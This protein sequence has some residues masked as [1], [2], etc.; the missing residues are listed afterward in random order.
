MK[1]IPIAFRIV[2]NILLFVIYSF[3]WVIFGNFL[4][5]LIMTI[6]WKVVAWPY[7][8]IHTKIAILSILVIFLISGLFRKYFYLPIF[9]KQEVDKNPKIKKVNNK[10]E[11]KNKQKDE[12]MKIYLDKEIK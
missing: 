2:L 7:D 8:S 3:I 6:F 4:Y 5:W 12:K 1:N 10:K 9:L 11:E